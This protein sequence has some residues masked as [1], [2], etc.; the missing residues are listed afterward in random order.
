MMK[1]PLIRTNAVYIRIARVDGISLIN[2]TI[3]ASKNMPVKVPKNF[4]RVKDGLYGYRTCRY[5]SYARKQ[6]M[7]VLAAVNTAERI[8]RS[9]SSKQFW[10][11]LGKNA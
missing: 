2:G 6:T 7:Y 4:C 3:V 8:V 5:R 10:A 9:V 11:N 1:V